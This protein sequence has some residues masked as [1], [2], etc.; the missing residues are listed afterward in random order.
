MKLINAAVASVS[1]CGQDDILSDAMDDGSPYSVQ[2]VEMYGVGGNALGNIVYYTKPALAMVSVTV[3]P[4][5]GSAKQLFTKLA[6]GRNRE[7]ELTPSET[8]VVTK[9]G[10]GTVYN[11]SEGILVSGGGGQMQADGKLGGVSFT[12][13]FYTL[14]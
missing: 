11:Y 10:G 8:F 7:K 5:T 4:G 9:A 3:G 14:G 13:A 6:E 2:D 12:A 1:F